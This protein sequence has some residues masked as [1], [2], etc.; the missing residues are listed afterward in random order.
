MLCVLNQCWKREEIPTTWNTAEVISLYIKRYRNQCENYRGISLLNVAYKVYGQIVN[1]RLIPY[2]R[3]IADTLL[4]EEQNGFR[5]GRSCIGNVIIIR[6]I[7]EKRREYNLE[8][9]IGFIDYEK[10][11]TGSTKQN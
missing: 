6:Q 10:T 5:K 2:N 11:S 1:N 9:H 8:T 3:V 7:I 4:L